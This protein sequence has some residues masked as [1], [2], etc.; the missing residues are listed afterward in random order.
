MYQLLAD[1]CTQ[2]FYRI[3]IPK[4]K[5]DSASPIEGPIWQRNSFLTEAIDLRLDNI[6]S[7]GKQNK[8]D[9]KYSLFIIGFLV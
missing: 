5:P 8:I 7:L 2:N 3:P 6:R 1:E 4:Y 9:R